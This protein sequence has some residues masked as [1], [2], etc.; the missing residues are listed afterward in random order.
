MT[1]TTESR[2]FKIISFIVTDFFAGF[3][4]ANIIYYAKARN[5]CNALSRTEVISMLWLNII[6]F[7]FAIILFLWSLWR[8]I[9]SGSYRQQLSSNVKGYFQTAHPGFITTTPKSLASV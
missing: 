9:F 7:I 2:W 8:L 1:E 4:L 5:N 6:L 3:S